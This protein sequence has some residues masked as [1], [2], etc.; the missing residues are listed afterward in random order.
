MINVEQRFL[1]I[2]QPK[3]IGIFI[4]REEFS[5]FITHFGKFGDIELYDCLKNE[6]I[7]KTRGVYIERF[8]PDITDR[9]FAQLKA[10]K[11][12]CYFDN[13]R[14]QLKRKYPKGRLKQLYKSLKMYFMQ[15]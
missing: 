11:Y 10:K 2:I 3:G 7:L 9:S 8:Y 12:Y 6:R 13:Y 5:T 1:A 14:Y 4:S 15:E